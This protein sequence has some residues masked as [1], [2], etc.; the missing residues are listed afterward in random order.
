M[1]RLEKT[2]NSMYSVQLSIGTS[3][4]TMT[5]TGALKISADTMARMNKIAKVDQVGKTVLAMKKQMAMVAEAEDLVED[6]MR[7]SDEEEET[8]VEVQRV[9]DTMALAAMGPLAQ[10]TAAAAPASAQAAEQ[11]AAA[12]PAR[13]AVPA[14]A[15]APPKP[16][17]APAQQPTQQQPAPAAAP[18]AATAA[19]DPA[20]SPEDEI[21]R[22]K[23]QLA[24]LEAGPADGLLQ[25]GNVLLTPAPA[26]AP[27]AA[28]A[29]E[30]YAPPAAETY[31]P[32]AAETYA[33][34]AP[35]PA[36][37]PAASPDDDLMARLA[38]LN[39]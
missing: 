2:K 9:L 6:A 14:G 31:A 22:L 26:P 19:S 27:A 12:A 35:A 38:A 18:I 4:A 8:A 1:K 34:P 29:P 7:D 5:T 13:V 21:A 36:P 15:P 24:A 3:V 33:P 30:T 16:K 37:A 23:A 17:P 32:P 20:A 10:S 28:P 25:S 39:G 11:P